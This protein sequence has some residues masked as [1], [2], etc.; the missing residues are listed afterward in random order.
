M[1]VGLLGIL[2]VGGAYVP[3]DPTYPDDR[4]E[5]IVRDGAARWCLAH[6][7][8]TARL[9]RRAHL[10]AQIVCLTSQ[11]AVIGA[12]PA[13]TPALDLTG[14]DPIYVMYTSGSTGRRKGA[15][16]CHRGVVRLVGQNDYCRFAPAVDQ[17][18]QAFAGLR[19]LLAGG[20][21][22][23]PVHVKKALEAMRDGVVINGYG[24]TECTTFACCFRMTKDYRPT[25]SI[26][27]GRPIARTKIHVLNE[28]MQQ[29]DY[30]TPGEL[31]IGGDGLADGYL[32]NEQLTREKFVPDPFSVDP[33]A[34]LYRTGDQVRE[35]PDG[36]LEFLGRF[37]HQ[38]KTRGHRIE[39]GESRQCFEP[40]DPPSPAI[41]RSSYKR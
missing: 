10:P 17:G 6:A 39:L 8:T 2:K 25:A 33:D 20:D 21:V 41:R 3:L 7:A 11:E 30:G 1:I 29:V 15:L 37:D 4:L 32:N 26:P 24:P 12:E 28:R 40:M 36:N 5:F 16:I 35:L 9:S 18:V 34:R 27:I 31:Y 14:D 13:H 19:Q 38:V 22:L 23:S